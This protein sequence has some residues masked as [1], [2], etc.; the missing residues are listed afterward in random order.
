MSDL[1]KKLNTYIA[2]NSDGIVSCMYDYYVCYKDLYPQKLKNINK[3]NNF[4]TTITSTNYNYKISLLQFQ[5]INIQKIK[6]IG[7]TCT[8]TACIFF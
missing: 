1:A 2:D 3:I 4:F 8:E 7:N 6:Y 5:K